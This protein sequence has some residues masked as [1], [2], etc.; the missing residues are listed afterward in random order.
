MPAN[1]PLSIKAYV[2][3]ADIDNVKVGQ[4]VQ[5]RVAACPYTDYGVGS[6]KVAE[7]AADA[8]PIDKNAGNNGTQQPQTTANGI[9]EVTI[10]PDKLTLVGG[11]SPLENRGGKKCQ[12]RA[13]LTG[14]AD[15]IFK[16]QS[17][18]HFML[19]KARLSIDP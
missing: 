18:L 3:T 7:V 9:Y 2:A 8:K 6:G 11:A 19:S 16:E 12:L 1:T 10:V 13:G 5:M 14:R 15:I 4:T 17:I